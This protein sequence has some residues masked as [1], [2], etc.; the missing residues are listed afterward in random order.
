MVHRIGEPAFLEPP[1]LRLRPVQVG[2]VAA[3]QPLEAGVALLPKHAADEAVV[4]GQAL[5]AQAGEAVEG[6]EARVE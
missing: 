6:V 1:V 5:A 3:Q 2:L 4:E